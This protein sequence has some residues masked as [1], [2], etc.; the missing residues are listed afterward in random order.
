[1]FE[2]VE[3]T[4]KDKLIHQGIFFR[5]QKPVNKAL[6]WVHGLT[7]TFYGNISLLNELA[8]QGEAHGFGFA[9]SSNRAKQASTIFF[10]PPSGFSS[11][12]PLNTPFSVYTSAPFSTNP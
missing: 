4:T 1:M 5:P 10:K 11:I 7:S 3:I 6:L 12:T 9:L 8:Q 2:L